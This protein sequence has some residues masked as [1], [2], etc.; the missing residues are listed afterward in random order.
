[1]A[2]S[3]RLGSNQSSAEGSFPVSAGPPLEDRSIT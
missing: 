3:A 2:I 1:M